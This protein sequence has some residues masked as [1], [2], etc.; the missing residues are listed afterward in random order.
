MRTGLGV[1][2]NLAALAAVDEILADVTLRD[3][4]DEALLIDR[5]IHDALQLPTMVRFCE[6]DQATSAA[7]ENLAKDWSRSYEVDTLRQSHTAVAPGDPMRFLTVL[8]SLVCRD[9]AWAVSSLLI[10]LDFRDPDFGA[11]RPMPMTLTSMLKFGVPTPGSCF[12]SSMGVTARADAIVV[13]ALFATSGGFTYQRFRTW[14]DIVSRSE[15]ID[16]SSIA[17]AD[18]LL[19]RVGR[20]RSSAGVLDALGRGDTETV[21][22]LVVPAADQVAALRTEPGAPIAFGRT[23]SAENPDRIVIDDAHSRTIGQLAPTDGHT[24][25]PLLDSGVLDGTGHCP[26]TGHASER[27]PTTANLVRVDTDD[28]QCPQIEPVWRA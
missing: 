13:G 27:S 22:R 12:A 16:A 24:V 11:S 18:R 26:P 20:R 4:A 5:I 17:A 28:S 8:D 25:A 19:G 15:L 14:L 1:G 10:M 6:R 7:V 3:P 23:P 21:L 9:L 2:D